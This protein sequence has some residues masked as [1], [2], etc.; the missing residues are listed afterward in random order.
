MNKIYRLKFSK[1]L[2]QLVAVSEITV[3]H[4]RNSG[5]NNDT[6]IGSS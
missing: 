1:R 4:D 3:G 6:E 5:S 2:N